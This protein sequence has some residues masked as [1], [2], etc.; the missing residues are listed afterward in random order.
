MNNIKRKSKTTNLKNWIKKNI[1]PLLF[2][3]GGIIDQST[4]L[5][6]QLLYD[7]EAPVWVGTVIRIF[8][9]TFGAF[10]LFYSIPKYKRNINNYN[11]IKNN[12]GS[13]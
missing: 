9:M 4:D 13:Q 10:K 8:I 5:L 1:V 6:V 3:I 7:L 12:D 2:V 11:K